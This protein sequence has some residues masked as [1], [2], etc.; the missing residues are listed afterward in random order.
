MSR[1]HLSASNKDLAKKDQV[2][3]PEFPNS[4]TEIFKEAI[5][6]IPKQEYGCQTT[7]A[8]VGVAHHMG[9]VQP[10]VAEAIVT[11]LKEQVIKTFPPERTKARCLAEILDLELNYGWQGSDRTLDELI[12]AICGGVPPDKTDHWLISTIKIVA[13]RSADKARQLVSKRFPSW[14]DSDIQLHIVEQQAKYDAEGAGKAASD[15]L[16]AKLDLGEPRL[17][18]DQ[19]QKNYRLVPEPIRPRGLTRYVAETFGWLVARYGDVELAERMTKALRQDSVERIAILGEIGARQPETKKGQEY[20]EQAMQ[21]LDFDKEDV[22]V[23]HYKRLAEAFSGSNHEVASKFMQC[24]EEADYFGVGIPVIQVKEALAT[25]NFVEA[26]RIVRTVIKDNLDDH[27]ITFPPSGIKYE[28]KKLLTEVAR[29]NPQ[30]VVALVDDNFRHP[31]NT[32]ETDLAK[33]KTDIL[34]EGAKSLIEARKIREAREL[35]AR[36]VVLARSMKITRPYEGEL[37]GQKV[38]KQDEVIE[39]ILMQVKARI[40]AKVGAAVAKLEEHSA[41]L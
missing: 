12:K 16:A 18:Y 6:H 34:V 7:F 8:T 5:A 39:P 24:Y 29:T 28:F 10:Q 37:K 2:L 31:E 13:E 25:G 15:Y 20:T 19:E 17:A 38:A 11:D 36:A 9:E 41:G 14:Q 4:A 21:L 26:S 3:T 40:L 33:L 1:E 30:R 23:E 35:L 22:W 32:S 27:L